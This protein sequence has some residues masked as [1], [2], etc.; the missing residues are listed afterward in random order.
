MQLLTDKKP[1]LRSNQQNNLSYNP[2]LTMKM[3]SSN[4]IRFAPNCQVIV[5]LDRTK[6]IEDQLWYSGDDV[7]HFKLYS[8]LYADEVKKSLSD[9]TFCGDL[10]D[11]LGLEKCLFKKSYYGRRR[12]LMSSVLEEQAW[13]RLSKEMRRRRGL[14]SNAGSQI[15]DDN[16]V[17]LANIAEK[18]SSWAKERA[19]VAALV[20]EKKSRLQHCSSK[21]TATNDDQFDTQVQS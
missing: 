1:A 4:R 18:Y 8:T 2:I 3:K 10:D 21:V 9:G 11:I 20:L 14:T 15:A 5:V 6:G 17:R 7:D 19:S 16:M 13:Q 12:L